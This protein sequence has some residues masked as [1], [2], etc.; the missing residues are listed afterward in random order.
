MRPGVTTTLQEQRDADIKQ[1]ARIVRSNK[2][3]T[4]VDNSQAAFFELPYFHCWILSRPLLV[5]LLSSRAWP[6]ER[7][8]NFKPHF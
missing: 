3:T 7:F 6:E 8:Q 2:R 1:R 5:A 4:Q